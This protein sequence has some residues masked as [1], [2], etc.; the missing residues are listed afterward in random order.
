MRPNALIRPTR[1]NTAS[2]KNHSFAYILFVASTS[3]GDSH[4]QTQ[5]FSLQSDTGTDCVSL[6]QLSKT[7]SVEQ[8]SPQVKSR[9]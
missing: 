2:R 1:R 3:G 8:T 6:M 5:A 9:A 4:A 7:H